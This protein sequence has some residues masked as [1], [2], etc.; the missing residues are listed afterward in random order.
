MSGRTIL[1]TANPKTQ[2]IEAVK[3]LLAWRGRAVDPLPSKIEFM[4]HGDESRL[5]L[6]LSNDKTAYY[7]TTARACSCPSSAYRPGLPCKH[8]RKFF[9][10]EVT[11]R[12]TD[13]ESIRPKCG[14]FRPFSELPSGEKAAGMA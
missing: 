11:P 8:M 7:V 9:P 4:N 12:Q 6:V 3:T 13:N 5:M 10:V 2:S 14:A 1:E